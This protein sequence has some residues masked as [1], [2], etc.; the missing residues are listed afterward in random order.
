[1]WLPVCTKISSTCCFAGNSFLDNSSFSRKPYQAP[2]VMNI[3]TTSAD[4]EFLDPAIL[5]VGKGRRLP[6]GLNSPGVDARS[7]F[8]QQMS[9]YDNDARIQLLMQRSL[10][11]HQ[12]Q[13]YVEMGNNFSSHRDGYGLP[14]R[15]VDQTVNNNLSQ[16]S[17]FNLPQSRSQ[18]MSNGNWDG[19][20][21]V[22]RGNDL[23]MSDLLRSE[24]L[25]INRLFGGYE[26]SKFRMP[27][28]GDLYN[29]TYGI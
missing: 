21:E 17:Q 20:G 23:S 15:I 2:P 27:S 6:G 16:F 5:E 3:G 19:W 4:I 12:N 13:R 25:E 18:L 29:Q 1:M 9:T 14:P 10:S 22:P 8:P 7:T 26:D 24:R 11:P 28:P